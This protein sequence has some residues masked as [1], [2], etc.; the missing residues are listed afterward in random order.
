[1]NQNG[2]ANVPKRKP[3]YRRHESTNNNP[4]MKNYPSAMSWI[5][6][7][8]DHINI[9]DNAVTEL[10][11]ALSLRSKINFKHL[12]FG[13]FQSIES[14]WFYIR[15]TERDDR[16]RTLSGLGL[17][18]F[19]KTLTLVLVK[20][21]R[22]IILEAMYQRI[23]QN[24]ALYDEFFK[25]ELP[26]D[27]YHTNENGIRIRPNFATWIIAG[28]EEIRLAIQAQRDPDFYYFMNDTNEDMYY[29]VLPQRNRK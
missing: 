11:Q 8:V 18:K 23:Y 14:F 7:D 16:L 27:Y 20:N 25:S 29:Y 22:A 5:Q 2:L 12:I 17:N 19:A 21:F 4:L 13:N 10:G 26:F 15:S 28:L 24:A 6:D 9:S 1:M 3:T